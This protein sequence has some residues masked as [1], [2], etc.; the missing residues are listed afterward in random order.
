MTTNPSAMDLNASVVEA[1]ADALIATDSTGTIVLWSPA[2]EQLLGYRRAEAVGQTLALIILSASRPAHIAG[3]HRAM[4]SG[5]TDTGGAPVIV[6]PIR[7]DGTRIEVEMC[8]GLITGDDGSVMGAIAVLR[9]TG[10]RRLIE[11]Y[12]PAAPADRG[13]TPTQVDCLEAPQKA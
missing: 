12:A 1:M 8:I 9:P 2:A 13:P 4:T 6:T 5:R 10:T 7:A 11:S 3:F